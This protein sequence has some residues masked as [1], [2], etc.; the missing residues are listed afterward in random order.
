MLI[1]LFI[2]WLIF[3]GRVTLEIII[4]GVAVS[5][6]LDLLTC[7]MMGRK[8]NA[9]PKRVVRRAFGLVRY[10]VFFVG[11][12]IRSSVRVMWLVLHPGEEID[13]QLVYFR[14]GI[15]NEGLRVLLAN[16]IT[17]T[18]GTITVEMEG[19]LFRVHGLD[20]ELAEGLAD[21][22]MVRLLKKVEEGEDD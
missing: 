8:F 7:K 17:F 6:T 3:N 9:R 11:E 21:S 4:S 15:K 22:E 20:R 5:L 1:A 13:P 18:P 16:S 14:S 19:D 12:L 2:L 10:L